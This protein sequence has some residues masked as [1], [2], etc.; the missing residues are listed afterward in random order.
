MPI[1]A[2]H[3][4]VAFVLLIAAG[5]M[6]FAGEALERLVGTKWKI[7]AAESNGKSDPR[8]EGDVWEFNEASFTWESPAGKREVGYRINDAVTPTEIDWWDLD[9]KE[10]R[11]GRGIV[12]FDDKSFQIC[13]RV[14]INGRR[15]R[16]PTEF[17]T[18]GD[19][20]VRM[21]LG[22]RVE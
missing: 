12:R 6:A 15:V 5:H 2:F 14:S 21:L 10:K 1:R 4:V 7:M 22:T 9:A 8:E 11:F 20:T 13:G 18:K 17:N 3:G 16:R 19:A